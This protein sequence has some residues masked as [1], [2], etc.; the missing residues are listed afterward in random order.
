MWNKFFLKSYNIYTKGTSCG[1]IDVKVEPK[2]VPPFNEFFI[3]GTI[4]TKQKRGPISEEII[5]N[6]T[7]KETYSEDIQLA[8][9]AYIGHPY[10]FIPNTVKTKIKKGTEKNI[11]IE[12]IIAEDYDGKNTWRIIDV[13]TEKNNEMIKVHQERE[14]IIVN[15]SEKLKIGTYKDELIIT[16]KDEKKNINKENIPLNIEVHGNVITN[17]ENLNYGVV[18]RGKEY[19]TTINL[20]T[21]IKEKFIIEEAKT[22]IPIRLD[23]EKDTYLESHRIS[24]KLDENATYKSGI[25]SGEI[26][27]KVVLSN[28]DEEEMVIPVI[29]FKGLK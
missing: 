26:R 24:A 15:I 10:I 18:R 17:T 25:N 7:D 23:Y 11:K 14:S 27:I 28:G 3:Q 12:R 22:N 13:H 20:H 21:I 5:I 29:L 1:C 2:I 16:I 8:I 9:K 19:E 4:D 6:L